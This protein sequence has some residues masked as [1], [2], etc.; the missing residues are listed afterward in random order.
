MHQDAALQRALQLSSRTGDLLLRNSDQERAG[1]DRLASE[2]LES[3]YRC[4]AVHLSA[5]VPVQGWLT[6]AAAAASQSS[7]IQYANE[8]RKPA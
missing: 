5:Q 3:E 6:G 8:S 2:L 7:G 1:I 4:V